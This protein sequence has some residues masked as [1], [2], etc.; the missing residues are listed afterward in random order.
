MC[1]KI[2]RSISDYE[3]KTTVP[4]VLQE[5]GRIHQRRILYLNDYIYCKEERYTIHWT[6]VLFE[7]GHRPN[8]MAIHN[9]CNFLQNVLYIVP[10]TLSMMNILMEADYRLSHASFLLTLVT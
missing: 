10:N 6:H 2:V 3:K 4:I 9:V 7:H 1:K 8:N 5:Q